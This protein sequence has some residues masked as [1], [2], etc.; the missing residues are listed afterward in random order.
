MAIAPANVWYGLAQ[1]FPRLRGRRFE[2][3]ESNI[4]PYL[5]AYNRVYADTCRRIFSIWRIGEGRYFLAP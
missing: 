3:Q 4:L 5:F 1:R 2:D